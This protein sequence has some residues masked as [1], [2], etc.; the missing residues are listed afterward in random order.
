[1]DFHHAV[2]VR[3]PIVGVDVVIRLVKTV[4]DRNGSVTP[5]A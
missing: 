3:M 1:M 2:R 4:K 5:I